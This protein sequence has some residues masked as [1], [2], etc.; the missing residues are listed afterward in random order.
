MN[1][2]MVQRPIIDAKLLPLMFKDV[3]SNI[4]QPMVN[5]WK[6]AQEWSKLYNVAVF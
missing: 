2:V 3:L 6:D 4:G 5:T 1:P